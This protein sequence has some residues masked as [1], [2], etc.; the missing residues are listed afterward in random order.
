MHIFLTSDEHKIH[1]EQ[2]GQDQ[3]KKLQESKRQGQIINWGLKGEKEDGQTEDSWTEID[4][5]MLSYRES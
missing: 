2:C 4:K 5:V 3:D 1:E